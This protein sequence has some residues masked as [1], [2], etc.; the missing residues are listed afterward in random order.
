MFQILCSTV[1]QL[2]A[3]A[4]KSTK[5][6]MWIVWILLIFLMS[7]IQNCKVNISQ[8]VVS[9]CN[10]AGVGIVH[11]ISAVTVTNYS[12]FLGSLK[13]S[14]LFVEDSWLLRIIFSF[15]MIS[16]NFFLLNLF[17]SVINKVPSLRI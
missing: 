13:Y 14:H 2:G 6:P 3:P 16:G 9:V 8:F 5:Q 10:S 1:K 12:T 11:G 7:K 15:F 4:E 17:I